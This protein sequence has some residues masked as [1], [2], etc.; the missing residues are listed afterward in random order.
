MGINDRDGYIEF[1][2]NIG[3]NNNCKYCP[4]SVL[5]NAYKDKIKEM[6]LWIF[7]NC[8]KNIP[9]DFL[10]VFGGMSEPFQNPYVIEMIL[11]AHNE[12]YK[13]GLYTTFNGLSD[14]GYNYLKNIEFEVIRLH[15]PDDKKI[16]NIKVDNKYIRNMLKF[17]RNIKSK[18][19]DITDMENDDE[20]MR[21]RAGNLKLLLHRDKEKKYDNMICRGKKYPNSQVVLPNGDVVICC[22]DYGLKYKMG[23]L[24]NQHFEEVWKNVVNSKLP[25][26]NEICKYCDFASEGEKNV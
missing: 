2:L 12:G 15:L 1:T 13:I 3:C 18:D 8:L 10:I 20:F 4:Q 6:N 26:K 11:H 5:R 22:N 24:L 16:M 9:K 17:V 21:S 14:D 19:F 25:N 7:K 23:N